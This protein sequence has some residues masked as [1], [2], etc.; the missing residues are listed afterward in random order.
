MGVGVRAKMRMRLFVPSGDM[1]CDE[2]EAG[3][4]EQRFGL[5]PGVEAVVVASAIQPAFPLGG[6][7]IDAGDAVVVTRDVNEEKAPG[8]QETAKFT[9]DAHWFREG[10]HHI[11][12]E[13]EGESGRGQRQFGQVGFNESNALAQGG[14]NFRECGG[15]SIAGGDGTPQRQERRQVTALAGG[16]I[17]DGTGGQGG[18]ERKVLRQ[19]ADRTSAPHGLLSRSVK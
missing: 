9:E 1:A 18:G 4:D 3:L 14:G 5:G 6:L 10:L 19:E 7:H 12:E 2:F 13:H 16:G 17:E 15:R 11:A 8:D